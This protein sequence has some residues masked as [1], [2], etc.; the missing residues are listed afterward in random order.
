M[1]VIKKS[2]NKIYLS[3]YVVLPLIIGVFLGIW[4]VQPP[5]ANEDSPAFQRMMY[6]IERFAVQPRIVGTTEL[7]HTRTMIV[8]EIENMGLFPITH[9]TWYTRDE[10]ISANRRLRGGLESR[11]DNLPDEF[12]VQNIFVKLESSTTDRGIMFVSH[13]DTWASSPGAADAMMPVAAMLEA[14]RAQSHNE[15][16]ANNIYF[17]ITDGEEHGAIGALAF[18]DDHPELKDKIDMV[19]NLE[20]QGNR[21]GLILFETS[22]QA[23][24]MLNVYRRAVPSPLG[25]SI[26]QT[27]Y[28]SWNTYTDFCFFLEYGWRGINMAIVEGFEHYHRP[29]DNYENLNNNTA[30]HYLTTTLGLAEYA[31]YNS[32]E[33]LQGQSSSAVFF[34]FLKNNLILLSYTWANVFCVLAC[35][36]ALAYLAYQYI[37]KRPLATLTNISLLILIP[38]S[39]VLSIIFTAGSYLVWVPLLFMTLTA[40]LKNWEVLYRVVQ[41]VSIVII[42]LLWIPLIYLIM[43]LTNQ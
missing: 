26:A 17:L 18:I 9:Y 7:E 32:L 12:I 15:N 22:P 3:I 37:K 43:I 2:K 24:S 10:A 8:A 30:W 27:L 35:L 33:E 21:G 42:S 41:M 20:A 11:F 29:T 36:L 25:F 23:Y 19:V 39:V 28:N 1:G 31:A 40:F 13:Y 4:Q 16:L 6:N 38:L 14:M 5:S 34:P